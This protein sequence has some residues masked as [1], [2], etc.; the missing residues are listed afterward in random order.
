MTDSDLLRK[1]NQDNNPSTLLNLT[2]TTKK[3]LKQQAQDCISNN[4]G[5]LERAK[6]IC[7]ILN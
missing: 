4:T 2:L 1:F 5:D 3:Y 6:I 7:N